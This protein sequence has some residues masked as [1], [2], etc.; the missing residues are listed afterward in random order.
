LNSF[1]PALTAIPL[2]F[3][4]NMGVPPVKS[5]VSDNIIMAYSYAALLNEETFSLWVDWLESS[6]DRNNA[7]L[8]S[9]LSSVVTKYVL[10]GSAYSDIKKSMKKFE[11][12][13]TEKIASLKSTIKDLEQ[14]YLEDVDLLLGLVLEDKTTKNTDVIDNLNK[15]K[16]RRILVVGDDEHMSHYRG[17]VELYGGVF[18]F[19]EGFDKNASVTGKLSSSDG[20]LLV[21]GYISHSKYYAIRNKISSARMEYV[22]NRGLATF[23]QKLDDLI[24]KLD[25]LA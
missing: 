13:V 1:E 20:V 15:L 8:K 11:G 2:Q 12:T 3:L 17:I 14:Q 5:I 25:M 4:E 23:R 6:L 10:A 7:I 9:V 22:N 19:A 18:D 21:S 16:G 24:I